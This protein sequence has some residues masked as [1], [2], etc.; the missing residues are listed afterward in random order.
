MKSTED[1]E[2]GGVL[3]ELKENAAPGHDQITV[4]N[5]KNMKESIASNLTKLVNE[6][7][8]SDLFPQELKVSKIGAICRSRRKDHM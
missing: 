3:S 8:I 5:I 7:L 4:I 1:Q 6:V 2:I